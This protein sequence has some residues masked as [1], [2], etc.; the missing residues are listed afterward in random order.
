M[1]KLQIS[2]GH[3]K[4]NK[5][6]EQLMWQRKRHDKDLRDLFFLRSLTCIFNSLGCDITL[7][8]VKYGQTQVLI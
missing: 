5:E 8:W 3:M 7:V 6:K 2:F 1:I 4:H